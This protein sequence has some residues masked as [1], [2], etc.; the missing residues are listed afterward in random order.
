MGF[1]PRLNDWDTSKLPESRRAYL[2]SGQSFESIAALIVERSEITKYWPDPLRDKPK[3]FPDFDQVCF[4]LHVGNEA[5]DLFHNAPDGLRGRYWQRPDLGF[6]ATRHLIDALNAKLLAYA[7]NN[8]PVLRGSAREM[9]V[10]EVGASLNAPSAKVWVRERDEHGNNMIAPKNEPALLIPRWKADPGPKGPLWRWT[11]CDNEIEVKGA[12]IRRGG[13]E[14]HIPE[15][16][17]DR[18]CQIHRHGYT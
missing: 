1:E 6:L 15:S 12:L 11:P 3:G 2:D 13:N 9:K 4:R 14:E 7:K 10:D 16:K 5:F 18:S 8:G 17:R